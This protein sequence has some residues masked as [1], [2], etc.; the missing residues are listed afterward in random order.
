[1]LSKKTKYAIKAL[2]H[3]ARRSDVKEPTLISQIAQEEKIPKK[4]LEAI[5]LDLKNSG[6]LNSKKGKGGGYYLMKKPEEISLTEI[7]RL[8]DGPIALLPCVSLR[9]YET[10]NECEDEKTCGIRAAFETIRD[11][12]LAILTHNTIGEI[13]KKEK[14]LQENL[15]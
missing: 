8:F 7:I 2:L 12:T 10:C 1:M 13:L 5:L 14:I 11:Q 6:F 3:L 15:E 4:F 9:Y